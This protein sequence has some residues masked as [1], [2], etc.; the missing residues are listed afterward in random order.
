MGFVNGDRAEERVVMVVKRRM[1]ED[2]T[3]G[4]MEAGVVGGSGR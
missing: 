1:T 3:V 4:V 2:R